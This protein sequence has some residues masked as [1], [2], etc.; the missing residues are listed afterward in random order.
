MNY[1]AKLFLFVQKVNAHKLGSGFSVQK[2][3]LQTK[4]EM[5]RNRWP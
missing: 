1:T 4:S 3:E 2:T 5:Q